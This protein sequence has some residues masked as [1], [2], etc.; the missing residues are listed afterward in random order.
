MGYACG[1]VISSHPMQTP[2][3]EN[4][5]RPSKSTLGEKIVVVIAALFF[6]LM[7]IAF[8]FVYKVVF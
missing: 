3:M 1:V 4:I 8:L 7:L 6:A 2:L 5:M